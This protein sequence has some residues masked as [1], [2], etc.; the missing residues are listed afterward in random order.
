MFILILQHKLV[1]LLYVCFLPGTI[2]L[3]SLRDSLIF[4]GYVMSLEINLRHDA[5]WR[6]R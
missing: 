2:C 1:E 6:A 4:Q 3:Q 5:W